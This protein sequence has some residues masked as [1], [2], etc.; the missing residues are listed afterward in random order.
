MAQSI[1][2]PAQPILFIKMWLKFDS[3][4]KVVKISIFHTTKSIIFTNY[5]SERIFRDGKE[6]DTKYTPLENEN[7]SF[8]L[9]MT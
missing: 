6:Y 1:P 4:K 7:M 3:L 5:N 2:L 9:A 8:T